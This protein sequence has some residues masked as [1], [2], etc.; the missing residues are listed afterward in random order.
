MLVPLAAVWRVKW[1]D[2]R[3][4][5]DV[6]IAAAVVLGLWV[7]PQLV[8]YSNGLQG[9]YLLPSIAGVVG[10]F[11]LTTA[12]L[13]RQRWLKVFGWLGVVAV[14]PIIARGADATS[15]SVA[16]FTAETVSVHSAVE[17]LA[18]NVP[19]NKAILIVADSGTPYG[20][21]ATYSVPMF[22]RRAG[23][24]S[25]FTSGPS[26]RAESEARCTLRPPGTT[27]RSSTPAV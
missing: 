1:F 6:L 19:S 21:E 14:L 12:Y 4:R 15:V 2:R 25:P 13:L 16:D 20:F 23:M 18:E 24:Q 9:R 22:L 8:L 26:F 17:F 5:R 7:A 27:R 10:A 11:A 3:V